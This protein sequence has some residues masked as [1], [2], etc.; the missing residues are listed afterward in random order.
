MLEVSRLISVLVCGLAVSQ[1]RSECLEVDL[2]YQGG[3]VLSLTSQPSPSHC[4]S[5]CS[6]RRDCRGWS[7]GGG[8]CHLRSVLARKVTRL[9]SVSA[10]AGPGLGGC[11]RGLECHY[12]DNLHLVH[13][14]EGNITR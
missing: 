1:V 13:C 10:S 8:R 9:G 2:D 12:T 11:L 3:T 6:A 5:S 4:S 7:W 14:I